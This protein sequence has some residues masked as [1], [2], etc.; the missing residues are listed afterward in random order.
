M[1]KEIKISMPYIGDYNDLCNLFKAC[2]NYI[3]L[4]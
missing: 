2:F 1:S 3:S 4:V